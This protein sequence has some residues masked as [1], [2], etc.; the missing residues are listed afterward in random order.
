MAQFMDQED[1]QQGE[2][3]GKS[4]QPGGRMA[5]EKSKKTAARR[6]GDRMVADM[7]LNADDQGENQGQQKQNDIDGRIF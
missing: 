5:P 2:R 4:P 7:V 3:I 6:Q 1:A